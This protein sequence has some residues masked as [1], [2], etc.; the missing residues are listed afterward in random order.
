MNKIQIFERGDFIARAFEEDGEIW[1]IAKDVFK[2]LGYK[3][4]SD[5]RL[6]KS[7][8][9]SVPENWK[10][11][12]RISTD[13]G[14]GTVFCFTKQGLYFFLDISKAKVSIFYQAWIVDEVVPSIKA[15]PVD[16]WRGMIDAIR[17]GLLEVDSWTRTLKI[18]PKGL[19][20]L[21]QDIEIEEEDFLL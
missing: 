5:K 10:G 6:V 14:E 1:F 3:Q 12:K 13:E 21:A 9:N 17:Q 16:M 4:S 8:I 15:E 20:L 2:S 7:L 18:T 11:M 19:C